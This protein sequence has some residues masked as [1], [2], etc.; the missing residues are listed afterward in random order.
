MPE[1]IITAGLVLLSGGSVGFA[2][3]VAGS[4]LVQSHLQRR[5]LRRLQAG[6]S[7]NRANTTIRAAVEP[8][9]WHFGRTRIFGMLSAIWWHKELRKLRMCI[10]LGEA[11]MQRVR[12]VWVGGVELS[13]QLT[14]GRT[15]TASPKVTAQNTD[16]STVDISFS[17]TAYL[18]GQSVAGMGISGG[19]DWAGAEG[20]LWDDDTFQMQGLAFVIIE[21][22]QDKDNQWWR[23]IPEVEFLVDGY[24]VDGERITNAAEV[25]RWW[26]TEREG[27]P[28]SRI[29]STYYSA[30]VTLC[31]AEGYEVHG[32]FE[33]TD[34]VEQTRAALDFAW[35]GRVVDWGGSLRFLPGAHRSSTL[36]IPQDDIL[37]LPIIQPAPDLHDRV[38]QVD[39]V[40]Y[41]SEEQNW[42]RHVLP[43]YTDTLAQVRDGGVLA[44]DL[45]VIEYVSSA[46]HGAKLQRRRT[47]ELAGKQVQVRVPYGVDGS[48]FRYLALAPGDTVKCA[49]PGLEN[50]D[51][52]V[53][54]TE[55]GGEDTLVLGLQEIVS[56]RYD[57][58]VP[59][60][61]TG[62]AI[63]LTGS[64]GL[65]A[66]TGLSVTI[67]VLN[68]L[69]ISW[70][71]DDTA[72]GWT[73]T[74]DNGTGP[75]Q[76]AYPPPPATGYT[77]APVDPGDWTVAL[78][79]HVGASLSLPARRTISAE[80]AISIGSATWY[81]VTDAPANDLGKVGDFA[82]D[83]AGDDVGT[84]YE[85]T[86]ADVWTK[87]GNLRGA[88]GANWHTGS[89]APDNSL[90]SDGDYYFQSGTGAVAGS[91]YQ[92]ASGAWAKL[93]DIDQG[94][95]GARWLSGPG[96]PAAGDGIVGD[97]FFR[98]TNGFVYEKTG[99]MEWTFLKDITGPQGAVWHNIITGSPGAML[100]KVG[101]FAVGTGDANRG[102]VWEKTADDTWT[103][104]ANFAGVDGTNAWLTGSSA[105]AASLGMDG[106]WYFQTGSGTVAG[107]IY[108]KRSGSWVRVA[109]IDQGTP[110]SVWHSGSGSPSSTLGKLGDFYFRTSNGNV[111]E[112]TGTS[113]W[114]FRRDLTGPQ[115][116]RG[117]T[118]A[119]GDKGDKG[120]PASLATGVVQT[121]HLALSATSALTSVV[122]SGSVTLGTSW[123]TLATSSGLAGGSGFRVLVRGTVT[124][125]LSQRTLRLRIRRGT[126]ALASAQA[127][128][129]AGD[130]KSCTIAAVAN[131]SHTTLSSFN[132][133]ASVSV[134]SGNRTAQQ[135]SLDIY[136][137][138]R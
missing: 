96:V 75:I 91:I 56:G 77:T 9:K 32:T 1:A 5:R 50:I 24:L 121:T 51:Y 84:I 74:W 100:G 85:K 45:G 124:G 30:A 105:P 118:G 112:K 98:T 94:T 115:G 78:R 113:T 134:A 49:A 2:L 69:N 13:A 103:M 36:T 87:Y 131:T 8:A 22:T 83:V 106:Q 138:K 95:D 101:D 31:T 33:S 14:H 65:P 70:D 28:A 102:T 35:D 81:S 135:A 25:R 58:M 3:L 66:P 48:P 44:V 116:Q 18:N 37:E 117:A 62:L 97:F 104:R 109:D 42:Q 21:L 110:G 41:Q 53:V 34:D 79:R 63:D 20:T 132:V 60:I 107:T 23:G 29:A 47:K 82:I 73:L 26:E 89:G 126:S 6:L 120:D 90:G 88:D 137:A 123:I 86:A 122:W 59:A 54:S 92:K 17:M 52:T 129:P 71:S 108:Q 72:T 61:P 130:L 39:M 114:T 64:Q 11:P 76:A 12:R 43:T 111:F 55:P 16:F 67:G 125:L 127:A 136:I 68:R 119:K 4:V 7:T 93:I 46:G 40:L 80:G 128:L 19:D 99:D 27:E 10:V 133:Q 57:T 15:M 38:N